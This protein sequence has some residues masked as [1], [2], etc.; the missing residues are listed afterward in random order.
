MKKSVLYKN[1][2]LEFIPVQHKS[3]GGGSKYTILNLVEEGNVIL[4]DHYH[5]ILHI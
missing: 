3:I 1:Y 4:I 2:I 5:F